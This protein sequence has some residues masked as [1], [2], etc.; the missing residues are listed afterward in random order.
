MGYEEEL[1]EKH[2]FT[3]RQHH[4]FMRDE[5]DLREIV[6]EQARVEAEQ[7]RLQQEWEERLR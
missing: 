4:Q 6:E 5:E 3:A 1:V 7:S 2:G